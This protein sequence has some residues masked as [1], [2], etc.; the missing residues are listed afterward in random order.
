MLVLDTDLLTIIQFQ[1]GETYRR[2]DGRLQRVFESETVAVTI[3]SLEEQLRGWLGYL[4]RPAAKRND[5]Q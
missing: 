3:V 2:L 4:N 5:A 1:S